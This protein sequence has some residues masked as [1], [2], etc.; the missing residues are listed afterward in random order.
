[1]LKN[2]IRVHSHVVPFR[3]Q[4]CTP[5]SSVSL[6]RV[7]S[8]L[9]PFAFWSALSALHSH[10]VLITLK[11]QSEF[12]PLYTGQSP[13]L[14]V[15]PYPFGAIFHSLR[16]FLVYNSNYVCRIRYVITES[17]LLFLLDP[18]RV[19]AQEYRKNCLTEKGLRL[20]IPIDIDLYIIMLLKL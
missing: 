19:N 6:F 2:K 18:I 3:F 1:M 8:N 11:M 9:V 7:Q 17:F 20:N 5:I 15:K 13:S 14:I 4:E 10:L 16:N 12:V